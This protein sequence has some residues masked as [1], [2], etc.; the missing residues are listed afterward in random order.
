MVS[1]K[2]QILIDGLMDWF[3]PTWVEAE[4]EER[5]DGD[6]DAV[7][8]Q[9]IGLITEL[10]VEGLVNAGD[11]YTGTP[12]DVSVGDCIV[13]ITSEWLREAPDEIPDTDTITWF[14]LTEKGEEVAREARTCSRLEREANGEK[15][16]WF[17]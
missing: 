6:H 2:E 3:H 5:S 9:S 4:V 8:Q 16:I 7:R 10:L 13:R 11:V 17:D 15:V 12:W 1:A 14:S